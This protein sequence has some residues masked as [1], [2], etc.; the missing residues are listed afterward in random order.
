MDEDLMEMR[1]VRSLT[2]KGQILELNTLEYRQTRIAQLLS[3]PESTIR[4]FLDK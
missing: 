2:E 1:S 4:P 3:R